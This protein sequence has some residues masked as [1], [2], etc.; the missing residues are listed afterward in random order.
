MLQLW[1]PTPNIQCGICT[2]RIGVTDGWTA[3]IIEA[4]FDPMR[5]NPNRVRETG[6]LI[7]YTTD[8]W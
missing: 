2:P 7:R 1:F 3:G 8:G 5:F 4:D 6:V